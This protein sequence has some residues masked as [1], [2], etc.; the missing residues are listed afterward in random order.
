M[1]NIGNIKC[2][3]VGRALKDLLKHKNPKHEH[4]IS[5][6][7]KGYNDDL[8]SINIAFLLIY[9]PTEDDGTGI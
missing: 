9:V 3:F 6:P 4:F 7:L 1:I 5:N 2:G 8:S